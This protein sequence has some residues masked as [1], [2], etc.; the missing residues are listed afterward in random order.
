MIFDRH[1]KK[2]SAES[3]EDSMT[4]LKFWRL[5]NN[6]KQSEAAHLCGIGVSAYSL[7]EAGRL[8]PSR[9]QLL[10]LEGIFGAHAPEML[11]RLPAVPK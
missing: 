8:S 1:V 9:E 7:I 11:H 2:S 10:K 6:L 5:T 3:M 4:N